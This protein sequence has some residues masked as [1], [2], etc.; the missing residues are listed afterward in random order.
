MKNLIRNL[1][2]AAL[3]GGILVFPNN[4]QALEEEDV[5][6]VSPRDYVESVDK[7]LSDYEMKG[8]FGSDHSYS[9]KCLINIVEKV[10]KK[11]PK[12]EVVVNF[13]DYYDHAR[14]CYG[15]ALIPR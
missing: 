13:K 15:T 11:F 14:T 10:N 8:I 9:Y 7:K 12:A 4:A 6:N 5:L 2:M 1:G 3:V